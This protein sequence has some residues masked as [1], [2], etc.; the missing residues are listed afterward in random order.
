MKKTAIAKPVVTRILVQ[1]CGINAG[2]EE[3]IRQTV[4]ESRTIPFAVAFRTLS[5]FMGPIESLVKT[6]FGSH[7]KQGVRI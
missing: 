4:S 1:N 7:K 6:G 2:D 5:K 3:A